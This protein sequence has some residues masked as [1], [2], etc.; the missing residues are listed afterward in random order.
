LKR[1]C[2]GEAAIFVHGWQ[3]DH[4]KAKERLDRVK[5]SLESNNFIIPLIELSWNSNVTWDSA[6]TLAQQNGPKLAHFILD[7][8]NTCKH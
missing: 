2:P 7:Y 8:M 4:V 1:D 5:T 6:K 3:I